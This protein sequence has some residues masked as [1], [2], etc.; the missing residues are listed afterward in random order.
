MKFRANNNSQYLFIIG[1]TD[2]TNTNV[3][4]VSCFIIYD[5][6]EWTGYHYIIFNHMNRTSVSSFSCTCNLLVA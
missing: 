4:V 5:I 6:C 2:F 3:S 1:D